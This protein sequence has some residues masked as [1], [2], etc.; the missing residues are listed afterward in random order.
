VLAMIC[1]VWLTHRARQKVRT[2]PLTDREGRGVCRSF[3][4][5]A[6]VPVA[7]GTLWCCG[8]PRAG[9]GGG[10]GLGTGQATR[11][12]PFKLGSRAHRSRQR[13]AIVGRR[14]VER[15]GGPPPRL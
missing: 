8:G 13:T 14:R 7:F 15:A 10:V 4:S 2:R 1:C 11:G 12:N 3:K 9:G 6:V 5:T